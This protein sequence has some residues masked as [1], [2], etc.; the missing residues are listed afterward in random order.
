MDILHEANN[1]LRVKSNRGIRLSVDE[2]NKRDYRTRCR[3][4]G[5]WMKDRPTEKSPKKRNPAPRAC[6]CVDCFKVC[7]KN[8]LTCAVCSGKRK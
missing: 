3:C 8:L 1:V 2:Y 4:C 5:V 7:D 6:V